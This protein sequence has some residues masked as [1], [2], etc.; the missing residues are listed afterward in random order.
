MGEEIQNLFDSVGDLRRKANVNSV[1]GKP[2]SAEGRTVIPVARV[3]YGFG[4]GFGISGEEGESTGAGGGM[5]SV[6]SQPLG[7][8][9]VTP[10]AIRVEPLVDEEKMALATGLLVAWIVPWVARTLVKLFSKH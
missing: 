10:E 3:G 6:R 5:G 2:I 8:I 4:V 7:V 9:E 1:F